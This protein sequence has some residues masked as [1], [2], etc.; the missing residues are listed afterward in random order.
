MLVTDLLN[1][2]YVVDK[3]IAETGHRLDLLLASPAWPANDP[4]ARRPCA[5]RPP[6]RCPRPDPATGDKTAPG[7]GSQRGTAE[8]GTRGESGGRACRPRRPPR[9]GGWRSDIDLRRAR[10]AVAQTTHDA[11][12]RGRERSARADPRADRM[13]PRRILGAADKQESDGRLG[14]G[15]SRDRP[16]YQMYEYACLEGHWA[17]RNALSGGRALERTG[18]PLTRRR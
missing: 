6:R 11:R 12:R 10:K 5:H 16:H 8:S 4:E 9:P 15:S 7:S 13:G 18:S 1:L 14:R 17:V 3:P 2:G